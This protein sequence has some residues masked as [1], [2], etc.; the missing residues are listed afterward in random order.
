MRKTLAVA[1]AIGTLVI[2]AVVAMR[3]FDRHRTEQQSHTVVEAVRRVTRLATVEMSLSNWQLRRD[4]KD[5]F[6]FIPITCEKTIAVF[7]RGKVA[8][9]F[10]LDA[11]GA[12]ALSIT[13]RQV[14]VH[15][16]A[17]RILTTDVPPPE[18]VV[19]D[20]SIC[21][22]VDFEDY[23][24]LHAEARAALQRDAAASGVLTRAEVHARQLITE[25]VRPF[26]L[27][28]RVTIDS[29]DSVRNSPAK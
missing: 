9:G 17:P 23:T 14:R 1:V 16:P 7:Y 4:A 20:G 13:E 26:G 18:L 15:L 27:E 5:L 12:I 10:D 19:A 8:A 25:I 29:T 2:V 21:N 28:A 11:P 24:R 3:A 22:P 6:G